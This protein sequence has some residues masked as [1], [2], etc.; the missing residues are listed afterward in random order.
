MKKWP[1]TNRLW[2][3]INAFVVF[4]SLVTIGLEDVDT[5]V[6]IGYALVALFVF[7][8]IYNVFGFDSRNVKR[9]RET[10]KKG[11]QLFREK[12]FKLSAQEFYSVEK[13]GAKLSYSA[14]AII[15][16]GLIS[17]GLAM[18]FGVQLGLKAQ[19]H[20]LKEVHEF[21]N[22]FMLLF[23][24]AHVLGVVRAECTQEPN[25]VSDMINGG[26]E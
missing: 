22:L 6:K 21:F 16:L 25:I 23:I 10:I 26:K 18:R 15:L 14:L 5:H 3:W 24:A 13:A 1:L 9:S 17:T 7:R 20:A 4:I 12:K 2:H 8:L 19:H 11:L